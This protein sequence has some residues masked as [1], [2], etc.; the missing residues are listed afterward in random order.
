MTAQE[1]AD[2]PHWAF[3]MV[4]R[5]PLRFLSPQSWH[6]ACVG[7]WRGYTLL[8]FQHTDWHPVSVQRAFALPRLPG[9]LSSNLPLGSSVPVLL[10]ALRGTAF[11]VSVSTPCWD[12]LPSD[13]FPGLIDVDGIGS[14]SSS[15]R[16]ERPAPILLW[17]PSWSCP[18][19]TPPPICN[20]N[21]VRIVLEI[22]ALS[23]AQSKSMTNFSEHLSLLEAVGYFLVPLC[24]AILFQIVLALY[25][26][27]W[28]QIPDPLG[29]I[30]G[31]RV[32]CHQSAIG[33]SSGQL[34]RAAIQIPVQVPVTP[35]LFLQTVVDKLSPRKIFFAADLDFVEPQPEEG[36]VSLLLVP[37]WLEHSEHAEVVFDFAAV[38]GPIYAAI[39]EKN[40]PHAQVIEHA[41]R[42]TMSPWDAFQTG[43]PDPLRSDKTIRVLTGDT[44]KFV[45]VYGRPH[46]FPPSAECL[47]DPSFLSAEIRQIVS[48]E[49]SDSWLILAPDVERDILHPGQPGEE[50]ELHA[51]SA[52]RCRRDR[53][54]L[55]TPDKATFHPFVH[56]GAL[57]S[58]V[59]AARQR[60]PAEAC[61]VAP[62]AFIILDC[63]PVG[64]KP[65]FYYTG[66][67]HVGE[68][69]LHYFLD[70]RPPRGY[71]PVFS[72]LPKAGDAFCVRNGGVLHV[73]F[74]PSAPPQP[75]GSAFDS[76]DSHAALSMRN[77]YQAPGGHQ[78]VPWQRTVDEH[79]D[80]HPPAR[81]DDEA[82][83]PP[84]ATFTRDRPQGAPPPTFLHGHFLV[85]APRYR[86]E[87]LPLVLRVPCE[88]DDA[89]NEVQEARNEDQSLYFDTLLPVEP[90]PDNRFACILSL[91]EW[92]TTLCHVLVDLRQVDGRLFS[93]VVPDRLSRASLLALVS[94]VMSPG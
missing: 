37:Q 38:G 76:A 34:P 70:L 29:A 42:H 1:A 68:A 77:P 16:L 22:K 80:V 18:W 50:L 63:R 13:I 5:D 54:M 28:K 27:L 45:P 14:L 30:L 44:I 56:Q 51:A 6:W 17:S 26:C 71:R 87:V 81:Y 57:L 74:E 21:W 94:L 90:Q 62:G 10:Q 79:R 55:C 53:L 64:R 67:S 83:V 78:G 61:G 31:V 66:D 15:R 23:Y 12:P 39:V 88:Q 11:D 58:G 8:V 92:A 7:L 69:T 40:L 65:T 86:A 75:E 73:D 59:I 60:T 4:V 32:A 93:I 82:H 35:E 3:V 2:H 72:G 20:C 52:L 33:F 49:V 84:P 85:F 19:G 91:P 36:Y 24:R 41:S 47:G 89:L 43:H 48:E 46:W 9:F 25:L